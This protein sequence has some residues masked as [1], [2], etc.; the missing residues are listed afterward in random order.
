MRSYLQSV[1]DNTFISNIQNAIIAGWTGITLL[2][3]FDV[4]RMQVSNS[5][6]KHDIL[7]VFKKSYNRFGLKFFYKGYLNSLFNVVLY[8]GCY[9][10]RYDAN[11]HKTSNLSE[12][13]LIAYFC[14]LFS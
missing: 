1:R 7:T 13:A 14:T 10:G 8:R 12:K 3:P 9:N 11:K 2:Y 6:K 4:L 5:I